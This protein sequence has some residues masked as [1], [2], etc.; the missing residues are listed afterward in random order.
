MVDYLVE[1]IRAGATDLHISPATGAA[2]RVDGRFQR[3]DAPLTLASFHDFARLYVPSDF[4]HSLSSADQNTAITASGVR[5]RLHGYLANGMPHLAF[6][7]LAAAPPEL[8]AL[9]LPEAALAFLNSQTAGLMLIGGPTGAGKSTLLASWIQ[10]IT[11]HVPCHLI[12]LEDPIEWLFPSALAQ[13]DQR[14]IGRDVPTFETGLLSALRA[15]ADILV[16]GELR[17]KA[18]IHTAVLAAET[19][20]LVIATVHGDDAV[21]VL[22]RLTSAEPG[23]DRVWFLHRL[24]AV[25]RGILSLR[26]IS[27]TVRRTADLHTD[28]Q[29][30][31]E[32]L[33]VNEPV[34]HLIESGDFRHLPTQLQTGKRYGMI[35]FRQAIT[36]SHA[37]RD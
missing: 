36:A 12:T 9:G 27:A 20:H 5:C 25:L 18:S 16:I 2:M 3:I 8:T 11:D 35:T 7:I 19:G 15:D 31:L 14:E 37:A 29:M 23:V 30:D 10:H 17:T 24:A 4:L 32:L 34:R 28:R 22:S 26:P 33:L 13:I 21:H 6:R 1:A